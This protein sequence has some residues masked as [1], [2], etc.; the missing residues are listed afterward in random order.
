MEK[1][2][3]NDEIILYINDL[4]LLPKMNFVTSSDAKFNSF[5]SADFIES[6]TA[7]VRDGIIPFIELFLKKVPS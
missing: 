6:Y 3:E 2:Y 7:L 4:T 5:Y 1:Y